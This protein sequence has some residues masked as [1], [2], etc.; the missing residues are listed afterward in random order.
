MS[1]ESLTDVSSSGLTRLPP[2][3]NSNYLGY[4]PLALEAAG[5]LACCLPVTPIALGIVKKKRRG[6]TQCAV[7]TG[8]VFFC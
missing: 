2:S 3:C 4:I 5:M 7:T 8:S 1:P 6:L